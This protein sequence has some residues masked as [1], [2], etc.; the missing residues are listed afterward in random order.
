MDIDQRTYDFY[1]I[2]YLQ[3]IKMTSILA[4]Y[5]LTENT[6]FSPLDSSQ[7]PNLPSSLDPLTPITFQKDNV[8]DR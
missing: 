6:L 7:F 5:F 1:I 3:R 8:F 4:L 2:L